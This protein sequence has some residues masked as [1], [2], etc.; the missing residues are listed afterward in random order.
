MTR[1]CRS[2]LIETL[3]RL[4]I[5]SLELI[6]PAA[7]LRFGVD[8]GSGTGPTA[9]L[10]VHDP[11]FYRK[12]GLEGTLGAAEAYLNGWWETT[13][14]V[15]L[16]RLLSSNSDVMGGMDGVTARLTGLLSRAGH[17]LRKNNVKGS[18]RNIAAHYDLGEDFYTL[19]LD[20]TMT[21][22]S[23]V[24]PRPDATLADASREKYDRIC[25]KL[26]LD[27]S[28]HV[29][30]IGTGWAGFAL[31]AAREYGCRV[32]TTTISARQ[33][34]HA[35]EQVAR[36]DL[37]DRITVLNQDY[38]HLTGTYDHLVSVEMIE[39]V[40][41]RYLGEFFG[42][43]ARLLKNSGCMV[44]QAITIPDNRYEQYLQSVDFIQKYIFPGGCLPSV[45]AM[46]GAVGQATDFR[47]L[48]L[49]DFGYHYAR[50]LACW[51]ERFW[52][53]IDQVRA[54]GFDDRFIRMWH[55]YLC[56]CEAGFLENQIGVSQIM[57]ARPGCRLTAPLGL[58]NEM[59][60]G[61][62]R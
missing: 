31:H 2:K 10:K 25:R 48:H 1:F 7:S 42:Q 56:Y 14:L 58:E 49:E 39:A 60:A 40:G 55:Y 32:T 15:A 20:E 19:F 36:A 8:A 44:V 5:G 13:D 24:F 29:V 27:A 34:Q 43:C 51:R 16:F 11:R 26:R 45:G 35:C 38:R 6:E 47:F 59:E 54:L 53:K 23:G 12:L 33:Y 18:R 37:E 52:Q 9:D 17:A 61:V 4:Q 22:S 3:N 21:Y 41:H 28:Q 50:T 30:E 46:A 57:L 62:A